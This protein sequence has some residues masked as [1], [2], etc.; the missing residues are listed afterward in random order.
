[1]GPFVSPWTVLLPDRRW[2]AV[3]ILPA[4][5]L[6]WL[7]LRPE[8]CRGSDAR[9]PVAFHVASDAAD[10]RVR[11]DL[12]ARAHRS[13]VADHGAGCARS[14]S[15][16]VDY[17]DVIDPADQWGMPLVLIC[18]RADVVTTE[19]IDVRVISSG[20]DQLRGTA[21]DLIGRDVQIIAR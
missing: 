4:V 1:M 15:H 6:T 8:R 7:A 16:I 5:A 18:D 20:P 3:V 19:R 17:T 14:I 21:D 9:A 10:L 13:W 12:L 11:L 2:L